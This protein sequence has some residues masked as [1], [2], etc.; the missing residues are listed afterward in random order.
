MFRSGNP[1]L[2][3]S[4]FLDIGSGSVVRRDADAMTLNG[5]VNKTG[6][7]LLLAL[8]T[9]AF[10]WS[11]TLTPDGEALPVARFYLLGGAIGGF[12]VAMIT[13]FKAKWAPVTAPLYALL[14]GFFLGAISAIYE[15]RFNGI[16]FQAVLLTVGTL[17]ALLFAYRSGL[18][19]ATENF[20]LGVVA[21]TGG[22]ALVYLAT[23]VLGF[24]NVS[25][26][27]I[28]ESGLIGIGFS[29]FVVVIAAL[30]LVL[31]F[32]FI[33]NGVQQG[34]PKYMEWYGAFGLMV[35]LVWLY[36]EF[37]RLLS[38]LQSRN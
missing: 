2:Q 22:I 33:E 38:K 30:N 1:A 7:L 31:D 29:L 24:F 5:T 10:A 23:I 17:F 20:K 4:T 27:F 35:T 15:Q 16:V 14:E 3:E 18:I 8:L 12:I 25:V 6:I 11:Q 13:T 21:A 32:D 34:A 28:H 26:P 36:I 37:L 9:A 19:K